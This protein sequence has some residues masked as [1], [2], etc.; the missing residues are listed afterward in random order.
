MSLP[1]IAPAPTDNPSRFAHNSNRTLSYWD[2]LVTNG[3]GRTRS[4]QVVSKFLALP[5]DKNSSINLSRHS[6]FVSPSDRMG[7]VRDNDMFAVGQMARD[8]FASFRWRY[9]IQIARKDQDRNIGTHGLVIIVRYFSL[10]P[11]A[12]GARLLDDSVVAKR[13]PRICRRGFFLINESAYPP[14]R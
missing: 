11:H 9:R 10:R 8:F 12:A 3:G 5:F 14:R 13:V 7:A 4:T 6:T 1:V 2:P